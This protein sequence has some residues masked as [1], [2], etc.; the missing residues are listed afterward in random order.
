EERVLRV[1]V[2]VAE[3]QRTFEAMRRVMPQQARLDRYEFRAAARRDRAM[4]A[5]C[6][7][8]AAAAAEAKAGAKADATEADIAKAARKAGW[9]RAAASFRRTMP[10]F[11]KGFR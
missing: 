5:I 11:S 4:L 7:A 10:K 2:A 9:R 8:A 6:E 3:P 1:D